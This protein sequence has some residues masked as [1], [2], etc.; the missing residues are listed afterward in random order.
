MAINGLEWQTCLRR[1]VLLHKSESAALIPALPQDFE[2]Y[3]GQLAHNFLLEVIC[4]LRSPWLLK[5]QSWVSSKS[6]ARA[7][8]FR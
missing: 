5:R 4:G 3:E 2:T 7:Q 6:S 1:I 8:D